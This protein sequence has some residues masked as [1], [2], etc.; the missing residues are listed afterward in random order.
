MHN[1]FVPVSTEG[2]SH[3]A[4]AAADNSPRGSPRKA[5]FRLTADKTFEATVTNTLLQEGL[6]DVWPVSFVGALVALAERA[7]SEV[8]VLSVAALQ[9][10]SFFSERLR[11]TQVSAK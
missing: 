4:A 6:A 2:S 10:D 8:S 11:S 7:C 5:P 1:E 9:P 3:K